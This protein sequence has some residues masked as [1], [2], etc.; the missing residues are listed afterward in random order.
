LVCWMVATAALLREPLGV[1]D[2]SQGLLGQAA[3]YLDW[4]TVPLA[5]LVSAST[6]A[7]F[8]CV[9]QGPTFKHCA[10]AQPA[11]PAMNTRL[12]NRS[13]TPP[14]GSAGTTKAAASRPP[15]CRRSDALLCGSIRV[16][17]GV[18]GGWRCVWG[19]W[20]KCTQL[21]H[22]RML[23]PQGYQRAGAA[24]MAGDTG[25]RSG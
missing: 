5:L 15:G 17:M 1:A 25:R 23:V 12:L 24:D 13:A 16:G 9:C 19:G 22:R 10:T 6:A 18:G 11:K 4:F 3:H 8:C 2:A 14:P 20:R 7:H 21:Q